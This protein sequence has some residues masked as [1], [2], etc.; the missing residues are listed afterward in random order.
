MS[1]RIYTRPE[2]RG[3]PRS[4]DKR[5]GPRATLEP[6]QPI[7]AR[8]R[9]FVADICLQI[10]FAKAT[11][12]GDIFVGSANT[13]D[14]DLS[15]SYAPMLL[16]FPW[17]LRCCANCVSNDPT[18]WPRSNGSKPA[19]MQHGEAR[20]LVRRTSEQICCFARR[21]ILTSAHVSVRQTTG[22]RASHVGKTH[23]AF[24]RRGV[25]RGFRS[26]HFSPLAVSKNVAVKLPKAKLQ[27]LAGR[28]DAWQLITVSLR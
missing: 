22:S 23:W 7:T 13:G 25:R 6:P 15:G 26:L 21:L 5:V 19:M 16:R 4:K 9:I 8:G 3:A 11:Y 20:L 10:L 2:E 24:H 28:T 27:G 18:L 14:G 1:G 17:R 12:V